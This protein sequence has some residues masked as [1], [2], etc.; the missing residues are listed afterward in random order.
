MGVQLL[1]RVTLLSSVRW[2]LLAGKSQVSNFSELSM[3]P[4]MAL[5]RARNFE[6]NYEGFLSLFRE[7]WVLLHS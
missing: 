1:L 6:G 2:V 5:A 7:S 4:Y 3:A